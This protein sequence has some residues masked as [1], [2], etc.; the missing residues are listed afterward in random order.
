[1]TLM[2]ISVV[3]NSYRLAKARDE[4]EKLS[5]LLTKIDVD[6][7]A[8]DKDIRTNKVPFLLTLGI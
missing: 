6:V 1:M 5:K 2:G 8:I 4:A 3:S 7:Q